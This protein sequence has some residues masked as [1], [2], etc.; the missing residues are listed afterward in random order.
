[1]SS[2]LPFKLPFANPS[3]PSSATTSVVVDTG[4]YDILLNGIGFRLATD[5]SFPFKRT[6]EP[7]TIRRVDQS[8][9]PGE[10]T[11][12]QLPWI[13]SQSSFHAGAGQQNLEAPFTAFQYQQEQV[14]HIRFDTSLGVDVWTPGKV[15][16]LPD[17]TFS[18]F[19]FSATS[20]C[21]ATVNG[22]DYAIIGGNQSLYQA[23]WLGG[24]DAAP[25]ITQIDLSGSTYGGISNCNITSL[26]TDG[27][28]YYALIQLTNAGFV[29]GV[30]TY[31]AQGS[32]T[33]TAAPVALYEAPNYANAS[34]R[35]NLCVDPDF[36]G[37]SIN[38]AWSGTGSATPTIAPSTTQAR[39]GTKSMKVTATGANTFFEGVA[40]S[41]PSVVG[42][43]YTFTAYVYNPS[44]GGSV[45]G[46]A[47]VTGGQFGGSTTA[48]N[49]WTPISITYKATAATT[50]FTLYFGGSV[51]VG[52]SFYV[53]TVLLEQAA[54]AG[55]YFSGRT[56]ADSLY[57]YSWSGTADAST[58][59]ATPVAVPGGSKGVIGWAKERLMAGLSNRIYELP[60]DSSVAAHSQLPPPRYSHPNSAWLWSAICEAPGAILAAGAT[61]NQANV[62]QM[63]LDTS[64]ATPV[65]AGASSVGALPL[66][67]T[68]N[69]MMSYLGAYVCLGTNK[70]VRVASFDTYSGNMVVGPLSLVTTQ[71]V[72]GLCGADRFVYAGYSNQQADG[73]TGLARLDI[74]LQIDASGRLAWAPDLRP[75]STAPTG[76]GTVT[77]V[78]VLP[79]SG[80]IIFLTP[81]GIHVQQGVAGHDPGA[82]YWLRTSR[83]RYDTLEPKLFKLGSIRGTLDTSSITV[84]GIAPFQSNVNLGTFGPIVGGNPGDFRLVPGLNEWIQ[85]QFSLNGQSCV[86]NSYQ[87]KAIPAPGRQHLIEFTVLL[88]NREVDRHGVNAV[89]PLDPRDRYET[90]KELEK[91]GQEITFIE[92][93]SLGPVS[94]QVVIDQIEFISFYRP[95]DQSDLAGFITFHL[96]ETET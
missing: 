3:T 69:V 51:S 19:G 41:L 44:V 78:S 8:L 77:A 67:E 50:N 10:Q 76:R 49:A 81:E 45:G 68:V 22:I 84:T 16:R 2:K 79:N 34:P 7:T 43:T 21:T 26:T 87:A 57:T 55:S 82:S 83:I 73:S 32:I 94:T 4:G 60:T 90:L 65:L 38:A 23:A 64:G 13:K 93:T 31:V 58:S 5:Q 36:E 92:F 25:T 30:L 33:S 52:D 42:N 6:T 95:T 1:M 91:S 47:L 29:P 11:L 86:L 40:Y 48:T 20:L 89:D 14:A 39:V 62:M 17:T 71:P 37:A 59:V 88:M 72:Y 56:A 35:T 63:T 74:S 66:G 9:E 28:H 53:D 85:L 18:A 75:P 61:G 46:V 80:R 24:P 70:G 27:S 12:S 15:T 54:V 96:R